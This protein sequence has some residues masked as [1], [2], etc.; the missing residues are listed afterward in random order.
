MIAAL[1]LGIEAASFAN[2]SGDGER[3]TGAGSG[4]GNGN[5]ERDE[6]TASKDTA[7]SPTA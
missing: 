7:E 1:A 5:W 6:Y 4:D 3:G 2:G